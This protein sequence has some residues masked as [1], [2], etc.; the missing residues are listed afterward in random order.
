MAIHK[1][2]PHIT[3]GEGGQAKVDKC[4]QGEGWVVSQM[5]TSAWKKIIATIFVIHS[6]CI[7]WRMYGR[8]CNDIS[9]IVFI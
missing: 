5:W 3:G 6:A 1:G 9:N 8:Q 4:G 7:Q 2:C